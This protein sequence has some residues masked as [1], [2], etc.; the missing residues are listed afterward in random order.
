MWKRLAMFAV[1]LMLA[2]AK[3]EPTDTEI[4]AD[5][6]AQ[7]ESDAK[8]LAYLRSLSNPTVEQWKR[9]ESLI[10]IER[11]NEL[12]NLKPEKP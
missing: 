10:S 9:R 5:R 2:C 3:S 6:K 11:F 1:V 12:K 8:E 7:F 4:A